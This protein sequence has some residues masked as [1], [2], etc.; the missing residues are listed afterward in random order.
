MRDTPETKKQ[1][2]IAE[3]AESRAEVIEAV[4]ALSP[5]AQEEP[6]LGAWSAHDIV[7]HLI[8][9]DHA[10]MEAIEAIRVGRLPEFYAAY[11]AGWRT[12]N[13]GLVRQHKQAA[14]AATLTAAQASHRALLD[15]LTALPS[16]DVDR[17]YGVRSPGRR[18]V[19]VGMLLSA[20]AHDERRHAGQLRAFASQP[21][22]G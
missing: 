22:D 7:A 21:Q 4:L 11:D 12:F 8:G 19:T 18:R 20:E 1:R 2:L 9:W 10:N 17:D 13:A 16:G 14:L 3:L 15:R 6:F 5:A